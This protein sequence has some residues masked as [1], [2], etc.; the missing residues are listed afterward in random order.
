MANSLFEKI[1]SDA[2]SKIDAI[3]AEFEKFSALEK[4]INEICDLYADGTS[5]RN[6]EEYELA[7]AR[8]YER[9]GVTE[10]DFQIWCQRQDQAELDELERDRILAQQELSDF[11]QDDDVFARGDYD[12][13]DG[14]D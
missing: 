11:A 4:E 13:F 7:I 3:D 1:E 9:F 6:E 8:A 12:A 2:L 14:C 10:A 5:F